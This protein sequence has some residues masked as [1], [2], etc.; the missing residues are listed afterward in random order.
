[1]SE[2]DLRAVLNQSPWAETIP[3]LLRDLKERVGGVPQERLSSA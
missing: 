2:T 1:V 3:G